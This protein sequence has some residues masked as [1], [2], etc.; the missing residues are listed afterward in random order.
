M[1]IQKVSA[2]H[3]NDIVSLTRVVQTLHE[4]NEP[5]YFCPYD[6]TAVTDFMRNALDDPSVT[7]LLAVNDKNPV[8]Y[9]MLR[10]QEKPGHAFVLPR[11]FVELEQIAVDP[12]WRKR[13]VGA[14]LLDEAVRLVES[15]GLRDL[16][17]SVWDFNE[18]AQRLFERKGFK[19]HLHRMRLQIPV[20]E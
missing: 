16:E 12:D 14:A 4:A 7:F 8:G 17:L 2:V 1:H 5:R 18:G 19:S 20:R 11:K 6:E 15:L 9:A 10:V 13:G 3:L